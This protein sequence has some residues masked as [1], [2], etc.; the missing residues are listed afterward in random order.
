MIFKS[1]PHLAG[2]TELLVIA[3]LNKCALAGT[4]PLIM[5]QLSKERNQYKT[6]EKD[7]RQEISVL[8]PKSLI[9]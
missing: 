4:A 2:A 7:W 3:L 8:H 6:K 1:V 5:A 9:Y